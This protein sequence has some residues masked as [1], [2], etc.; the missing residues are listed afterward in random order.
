[1][2]KLTSVSTIAFSVICHIVSYLTLVSNPTLVLYQIAPQI[3][4]ASLYSLIN[5]IGDEQ[6]DFCELSSI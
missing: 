2:S 4:T 1:M 5:H 6:T 3:N